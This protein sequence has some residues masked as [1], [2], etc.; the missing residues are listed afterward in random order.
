MPYF[1]I[2]VLVSH[3]SALQ[4]A[5]SPWLQQNVRLLTKIHGRKC[6]NPKFPSISLPN[7]KHLLFHAYIFRRLEHP[8]FV[9]N[10][11]WLFMKCKIIKYSNRN[12]RINLLIKIRSL[13]Q[14]IDGKFNITSLYRWPLRAL[15]VV[16]KLAKVYFYQSFG[17]LESIWNNV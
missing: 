6:N 8:S 12:V 3:L 15:Y 11:V 2:L 14:K 17:I 1:N 16:K 13:Q 9:S 10:I 5:V 4:S 7:I